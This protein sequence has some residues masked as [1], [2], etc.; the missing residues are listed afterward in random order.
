MIF[1][2]LGITLGG[3]VFWDAGNVFTR[4]QDISFRFTQPHE[5][6]LVNTNGTLQPQ[7]IFG[8]NY[9]PHAIGFGIRYRTPIGPVR[10]DEYWTPVLDI[11]IRKVARLN[12]KLVNTEVD[13]IPNVKD[14]W[15]ELNPP[16]Q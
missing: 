4:L 3:V 5:T 2:R 16:K 9:M 15:K 10:L 6:A 1:L 14:P 7:E 11:Y 12:G 13:T 8:F